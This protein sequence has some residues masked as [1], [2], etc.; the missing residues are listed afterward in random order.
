[1]HYAWTSPYLP[2]LEKGNY[3][4][5]IT[6]KQSSDL[7]VVPTFGAIFGSI[8][9]SLMVNILG[10]KTLIVFSSIPFI[11]S[12]LM[13]G[14]ASSPTLLFIGRFIAGLSDGLS[15]CIVP[16]YIGEIAE[17]QTRGLLASVCPIS[18][19][20]GS[21]LINIFGGYLPMNTAAF[22]C[23]LLPVLLILTFSWF[24]ESPYYY[25]MRGKEKEA[26]QSLEALRGTKNIN[27]ELMRISQAVKEQNQHKGNYWKLFTVNS[28][29]RGLLVALGKFYNYIKIST[30]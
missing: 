3:T 14:L 23:V 8:A 28:N 13:V 21:L 16:M 2:V 9:T 10:R 1:M 6:S 11:V 12:W 7:A 30:I 4:F 29:R 22:V 20:L 26:K 17:P 5:Q 27:E 25:L 19:V 15:F 24:P 18:I